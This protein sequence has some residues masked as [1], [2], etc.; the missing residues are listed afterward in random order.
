[1]AEAT[2]TFPSDFLWGTATAA[3]QVEGHNVNNDWWQWEQQEGAILDGSR[4]GAAS[5]WW[6]N[7]EQDFDAAAAMGTNALRLSLEWSRIEPEPSVF[8]HDALQRYRE[9]LQ[10]LHERGLEPM[11]TLHH[12][13]NPL[14][15]VEK[16][17]FTSDLV[18]DYFQRYTARVVDA[19]GDLVPKWVTINEPVVYVF[20]RYLEGAFPQ[21]KEKG[22][23]AAARALRRLLSCHAVA[24]HTI[25]EKFPESL[26]GVAKNLIVFDPR[27]D[28][29]ALD[30]WW[31]HQI[32]WLYNDWWLQ[33]MNDGRLRWP[34]G[35]GQIKGLARSFDFMGVNYYTR[36]YARFPRLYERK[37]PED[38]VISDGNYGELYPQGLFRVIKH[39]R[40]YGKPIFITENGV[41]DAA[42]TLRP[43]FLLSHLREIW[44]GISFNWLI[45]GY[46]HWSLVD[47]F[48][49]ERGWTQRFGLIGLDPETQA[50]TMRPSGKLY[51]E[52][53]QS[54]SISSDMARRYALHVLDTLFPG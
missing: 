43:G 6:E 19:L 30:R 41:P 8:D 53:C 45:M 7:A 14:W 10:G 34:M 31:A 24:Y 25:K 9:M 39:V 18:V 32:S 12:F 46:Y 3:H 51:Q 20:N 38:A 22:W 15:L 27:P 40:R 16:G 2:M 35:R 28:G 42:D 49:W 50:R 36:F 29:N 54:G 33:A 1:M 21:G 23:A 11:V 52:I 17:D 4:S 5:D 13:S 37:W 26:V 47:N 44:R 48:E